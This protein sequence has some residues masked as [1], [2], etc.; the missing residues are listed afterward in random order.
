[1]V[2]GMFFICG[3]DAALQ[4]T[5]GSHPHGHSHNHHDMQQ[6]EEMELKNAVNKKAPGND[7]DI[8]GNG[9][10]TSVNSKSHLIVD[11]TKTLKDEKKVVSG[12]RTFF[13]VFALSFHAVMDGLALSL[14]E[15]VSSVWISFGAI[16]AH[17]GY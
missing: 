7:M 10:R 8:Q 12:L 4:K 5:F 14:Q 11:T 17:K 2:T 6:S 15:D 16:S 9:S 13:V 1:M 3:L